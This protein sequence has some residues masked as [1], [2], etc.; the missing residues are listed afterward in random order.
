MR[1]LKFGFQNIQV[2]KFFLFFGPISMA[3]ISVINYTGYK[4]QFFS[5]YR[6]SVG[7]FH[8]LHQHLF[9]W[10]V[11]TYSCCTFA[12]LCGLESHSVKCRYPDES[13]Y[14]TAILGYNR[15][16]ISGRPKSGYLVRLSGHK[17]KSDLKE[18]PISYSI[19]ERNFIRYKDFPVIGTWL[20]AWANLRIWL[21]VSYYCVLFRT[22]TVRKFTNL[23]CFQ[24]T[25]VRKFCGLVYP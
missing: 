14:Q 2:W 18:W 19:S 6:P 21:F 3:Y 11:G 16:L 23:I 20:Q 1:H 25:N 5:W 7:S 12:F 4:L 15:I 8:V 10:L 9:L 24:K 17:S 13:G 22:R